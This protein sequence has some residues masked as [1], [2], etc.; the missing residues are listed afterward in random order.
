MN[1]LLPRP[2]AGCPACL[3]RR[4]A[5]LADPSSVRRDGPSLLAEYTCPQC[6]HV[7]HCWWDTGSLEVRERREVA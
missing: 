7:W 1:P 4:R 3:T 2:V 6:G 5:I